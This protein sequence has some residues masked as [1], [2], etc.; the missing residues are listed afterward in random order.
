MS[1]PKKPRANN[2]VLAF[3]RDR[4]KEKSGEEN[5]PVWE[6]SNMA[7]RFHAGNGQEIAKFDNVE[8]FE[9]VPDSKPES[10][11]DGFWRIRRRDNRGRPLHSYVSHGDE[12]TMIVDVHFKAAKPKK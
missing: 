11:L 5:V 12:A 4:I 10:D 6:I 9:I 1:N 8:N 3:S 7:V 2:I